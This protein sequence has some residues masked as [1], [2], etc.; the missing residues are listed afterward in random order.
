MEKLIKITD[1]VMDTITTPILV[2]AVVWFAVQV[3]RIFI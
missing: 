1:K 2:L 3:V